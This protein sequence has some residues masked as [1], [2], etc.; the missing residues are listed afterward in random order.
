MP[1]FAA[2][3]PGATFEHDR[4]VAILQP[5]LVD[6]VR[7]HGA[8]A[9]ADAAARDL[10]GAQLRQQLADDVDRHRE[11]DADVARPAFADDR[12]VDADHLAAQV[13]QRPAGVARD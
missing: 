13:Q 12:R 8:D 3:P 10:A 7:R 4:A 5:E 11:A 2:A 9:D 6:R 1:A